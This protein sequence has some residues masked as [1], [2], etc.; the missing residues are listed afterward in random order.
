[1]SPGG[2]SV[3]EFR[4]H[5]TEIKKLKKE[6]V[7]I[8]HS[9]APRGSGYE[10]RMMDLNHELKRKQ[11]EERAQKLSPIERFL[12][13]LLPRIFRYDAI[14]LSWQKSHHFRKNEGRNMV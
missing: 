4:K 3:R 12:T 7:E 5:K 1:M 11:R 2:G 14:I 10:T 13:N 8:R 9:E 6:L